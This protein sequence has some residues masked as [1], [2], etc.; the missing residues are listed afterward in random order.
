MKGMF[1]CEHY[2]PYFWGPNLEVFGYDRVTSAPLSDAITR[3]LDEI[4]SHF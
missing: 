3:H 4:M 2:I 1:E